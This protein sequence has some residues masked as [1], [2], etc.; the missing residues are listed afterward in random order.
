MKATSPHWNEITGV[1]E[2]HHLPQIPCPACMS[3]ADEDVE[4]VLSE[5]DRTII[6]FGDA[7][8]NDLLPQN[9]AEKRRQRK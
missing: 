5:M 8:Y 1:C 4:F 2:K 7:T 9:F 6:D 3:E